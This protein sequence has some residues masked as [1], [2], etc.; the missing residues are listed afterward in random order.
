M[1]STSLE[2]KT[3]HKYKQWNC[4]G[5]KKSLQCHECQCQTR[6][7]NFIGATTHEELL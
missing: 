6:V 7:L 3:G 2:K 4:A 5:R 1:A